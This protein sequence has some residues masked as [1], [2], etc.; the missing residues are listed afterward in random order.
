MNG[1][2]SSPQRAQPSSIGWNPSSE[3]SFQKNAELTSGLGFSA[4]V[5]NAPT[6]I[7]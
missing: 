6:S 4:S 7:R 1:P 5:R 3:S 2:S